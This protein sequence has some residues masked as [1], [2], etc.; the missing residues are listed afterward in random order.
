MS[1]CDFHSVDRVPSLANQALRPYAINSEYAVVNT[2]ERGHPHNFK[3]YSQNT[4]ARNMGTL[5][6]R[7]QL[8]QA[9]HL[10]SLLFRVPRPSTIRTEHTR[11]GITHV[12]PCHS[13]HNG[14]VPSGS[15]RRTPRRA[16][17][18]VHRAG[19]PPRV[20]NSGPSCGATCGS[21]PVAPRARRARASAIG[22]RRRRS[23]ARRT[24]ECTPIVQHPMYCFREM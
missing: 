18:S 20:A 5:P 7:S 11:E 9:K 23:V 24:S 15:T 14:H 2:Q 4:T 10:A 19:T 8:H 13:K 16:D 21:M 1:R 3:F 17:T 6:S 22:V 12:K